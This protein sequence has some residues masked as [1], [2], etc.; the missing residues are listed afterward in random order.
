[1]RKYVMILD[2]LR[3]IEGLLRGESFEGKIYLDRDT[4]MI[5]FKAW[6]RKA[7]K[8]QKTKKL[9]DLDCGWMG[10]TTLHIVKYEKF[11]KNLGLRTIL[12]MMDN[13]NRQAKETLEDIAMIESV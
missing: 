4:H 5:T 13:D 6:N 2:A 1:M 7:P 10:E 11:A 9:A 12:G 3:I 8:H